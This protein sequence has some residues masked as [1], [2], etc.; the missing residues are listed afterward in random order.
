MTNELLKVRNLKK[1]FPILAGIFRQ[2]VSKVKAVDGIDF[3]IMPG[4]VLGLVGESGSGKSTAA[5]T[6]MRLIE[7]TEGE[8]T[9]CGEDFCAAKPKRLKELRKDLQMI[10]QDPYSSLNPRKT[11]AETIGEGLYYHGKVKS[12]HERND[13]VVKTLEQVGLT[14][15]ALN[16]Y[17]HEF[18]GGQQ[19]RICIGRA[20]ALKPRL[21]VC[22]EAV[23]AL[24]VSIQ[25][26]ILNLL[27]DLKNKFNLSYLFISH[28]LSVVRYICD[29]IAV[30]KEGLIVESSPTDDI[31]SNPQSDYTKELLNSIPIEHPRQREARSHVKIS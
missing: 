11:V 10:F 18:S 17:P 30:M 23:S 26:Q 31:F 2:E 4:E 14:A 27:L 1:H 22:D 12:V 16:R 6:A 21:I 13:L 20:V 24:D 9:F 15:E 3:S 29:R 28:D 5:R 19:Q 25:A 8:I 7:P